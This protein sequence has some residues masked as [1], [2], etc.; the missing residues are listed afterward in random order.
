MN[1]I[2]IANAIK[3]SGKPYKEALKE[4]NL[5]DQQ[6]SRV[7]RYLGFQARNCKTKEDRAAEQNNMIREAEERAIARAKAHPRKIQQV[8]IKGKVYYD[9][10][11][12]FIDCGG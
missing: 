6:R 3:A 8:V 10:T 1:L 2:V 12:L 9:V 4:Y 5:N 11:P 7:R